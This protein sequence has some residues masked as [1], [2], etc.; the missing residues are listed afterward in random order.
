MTP[1]DTVISTEVE[2]SDNKTLPDPP[3][4]WEKLD[5]TKSDSSRSHYTP[6]RSGYRS[7]FRY[8]IKK[9]INMELVFYNYRVKS[10]SNYPL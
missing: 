1:G 8:E 7:K 9:I 10:V 6:N 4:G 5:N 2:I 3:V